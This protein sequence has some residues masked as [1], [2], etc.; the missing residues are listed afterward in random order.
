MAQPSHPQDPTC[1]MQKH[2]TTTNFHQDPTCSMPPSSSR[3][4]V[5]EGRSL[6]FLAMQR[7]ESEVY[8]GGADSGY[9]PSD[10]LRVYRPPLLTQGGRQRYMTHMSTPKL[11][12]SGQYNMW[13]VQCE[14]GT[15]AVH[16]M[17]STTWAMEHERH[18]AWAVRTW[19]VWYAHARHMQ[20]AE[21]SS[22]GGVG[23]RDLHKSST[24][25]VTACLAA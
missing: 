9:F 20:A 2:K 10:L 23:G 6:G 18:M 14:Q 1:S 8:C 25:R 17:G 16:D 15:W 13:A 22:E 4:S 19:A 12:V 21:K 24:V 5:K 3:I 7:V 11:R